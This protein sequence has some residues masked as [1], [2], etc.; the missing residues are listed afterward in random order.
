M[1]A[2][3]QKY[4]SDSGQ[5][6]TVQQMEQ[7]GRVTID[8][9]GEIRVFENS[10]SLMRYIQE[11][12]FDEVATTVEDMTAE[13]ADQIDQE[14]SDDSDGMEGID[15][16]VVS[17]PTSFPSAEEDG[18][19]YD[20]EEDSLLSNEFAE[21]EEPSDIFS[22][23]DDEDDD[24]EF[25]SDDEDDEDLERIDGMQESEESEFN[26]NIFVGSEQEKEIVVSDIGSDDEEGSIEHTYADEE[27]CD[28][29]EDTENPFSESSLHE[30]DEEGE[31]EEKSKEDEDEEE[32]SAD[33]DA[34]SE[35]SEEEPK[36]EAG[37]TELDILT[38][39]DSDEESES[40]GED[41]SEGEDTEKSEDDEEEGST[42]DDEEGE[43]SEDDDEEGGEE[44]DEEPEAEMK[45]FLD[46]RSN[47]KKKNESFSGFAKQRQPAPKRVQESKSEEDEQVSRI[48]MMVN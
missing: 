24:D 41:D 37:S 5:V 6:L 42:E 3:Q 35:D 44:E 2:T 48:A 18:G 28:D 25:G 34:A 11:N 14:L 22:T 8:I 7:S 4:V 45:E 23:E 46:K 10:E 33:T 32:E 15:E 39:D 21:V 27:D 43:G 17:I 31:E 38:T 30:A 9:D 47:L 12:S 26:V 29:C 1:L 20:A 16:P 13:V 19:M 36:G 40:G